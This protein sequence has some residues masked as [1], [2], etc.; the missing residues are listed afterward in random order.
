MLYQGKVD[1][2]LGRRFR[3]RIVNATGQEMLMPARAD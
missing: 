2:L 1:F 3:G